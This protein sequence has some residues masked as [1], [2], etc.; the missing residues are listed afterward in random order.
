MAGGAQESAQEG[1]GVTP[2]SLLGGARHDVWIFFFF[3]PRLC[4]SNVIINVSR[5]K[6]ERE[7]F[8]LGFRCGEISPV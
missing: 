7:T 1:G 3:S 5:K 8:V 2:S 6:K 4:K